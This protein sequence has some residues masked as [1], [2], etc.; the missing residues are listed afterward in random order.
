[1]TPNTA[2]S[3]RSGARLAVV[4]GVIYSPDRQRVLIARRPDHLHQG[5]LWEFPGG[6]IGAGETE[7]EALV[8][9]LAEELAIEVLHCAPLLTVDHDYPARAVSLAVWSVTAFSGDPVG[10]EGQ[11][12]TWVALAELRA[13]QFPAANQPVLTRLLAG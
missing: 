2:V 9:E 10:N 3:E 11:Q 5:G 4:A 12:I 13:Y 7:R 6:K 8:R 1:M